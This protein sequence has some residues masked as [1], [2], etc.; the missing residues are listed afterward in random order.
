MID[1]TGSNP[2]CRRCAGEFAS[3]HFPGPTNGTFAHTHALHLIWRGARIKSTLRVVFSDDCVRKPD[4]TFA[5]SML[6][7]AAPRAV[8]CPAMFDSVTSR[9]RTPAQRSPVA[10]SWRKLCAVEQEFYPRLRSSGG[11]RHEF[12]GRFDRRCRSDVPAFFASVDVNH[13]QPSSG[14]GSAVVTA[15]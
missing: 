13:L 6:L 9:L 3:S 14:N 7:I 11:D 5:P 2:R 10:G 8:V 1:F 12:N 4:P 15:R